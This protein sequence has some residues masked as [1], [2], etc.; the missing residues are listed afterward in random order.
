MAEEKKYIYWHPN[1][2]PDA[3]GNV[4]A[5]VHLLEGYN[6]GSVADFQRMA[7]KIRETFPQA[8]DEEI[9]GGKVT[10]SSCVNGFTIVTWGAHIPK[11]EYPSW[12]QVQDRKIEYHWQDTK[13][14]TETQR[15]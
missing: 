13:L 6:Q 15:V 9:C 1:M 11:G 12:H 3:N 7:D 10:K 14:V 2:E 4:F 5:N 8:T